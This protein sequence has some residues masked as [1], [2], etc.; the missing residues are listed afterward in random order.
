[1]ST[2]VQANDDQDENEVHER[3]LIDGLRPTVLGDRAW[4]DPRQSSGARRR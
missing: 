2:G 4:R 3:T 1:V